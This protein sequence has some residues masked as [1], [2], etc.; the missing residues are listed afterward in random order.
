MYFYYCFFDII[1]SPSLF[2]TVKAA[3]PL[4]TPGTPTTFNSSS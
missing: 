1:A 2:R 4:L 3:S